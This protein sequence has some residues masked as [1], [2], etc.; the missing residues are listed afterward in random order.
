MPV[1]TVRWWYI[2]LNPNSNSS[3]KLLTGCIVF[4]YP[5]HSVSWPAVSGNNYV[6][7]LSIRL[8]CLPILGCI[9]TRRSVPCPRRSVLCRVCLTSVIHTMARPAWRAG[10]RHSSVGLQCPS[11]V[12]ANYSQ[13]WNSKHD[14]DGVTVSFN[15]IFGFIMGL[16][17]T[18]LINK[19]YSRWVKLQIHPSM[20]AAS[21]KI[22]WCVQHD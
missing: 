19:N 16:V 14:I 17:L 1:S 6:S 4:C 21:I 15:R 9:H 18:L 10:L 11:C 2:R 8:H 22:F 3:S 12:I 7:S 5:S 13:A 20:S